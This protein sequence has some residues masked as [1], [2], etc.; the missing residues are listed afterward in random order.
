M[1]TCRI[2]ICISKWYVLLCNAMLYK[3]DHHSWAFICLFQSYLFGHLILEILSLHPCSNW[4]ALCY[5]QSKLFRGWWPFPAWDDNRFCG[6]ACVSLRPESPLAGTLT[7][8]HYGET[9]LKGQ[10]ALAERLQGQADPT[11]CWWSDH[12]LR[13]CEDH[14]AEL[15]RLELMSLVC[16]PVAAK[17]LSASVCGWLSQVGVPLPSGG[18]KWASPPQQTA[19]GRW[20]PG[21]PPPSPTRINP[22]PQQW[23]GS[24]SFT[25]KP[26]QNSYR[27]LSCQ[28]FGSV[29]PPPFL[30]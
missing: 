25:A 11:K 28:C 16:N 3:R 17:G 4:P 13:A 7:F 20:E 9:R 14:Q 5:T 15:M 10:M 6:K 19:P 18:L 22:K 29:R 27:A 21:S 26:P 8:L 1:Y 24:E 12:I 2:R 30:L 23:Q